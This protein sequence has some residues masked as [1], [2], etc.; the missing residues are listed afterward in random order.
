MDL[1]AQQVF[2]LD[3]LQ[4][5]GFQIVPFPMYANYVGVRKGRC[6]ALL[7]PIPGGAFSIY[8]NPTVLIAGNFTARLTREGRDVFVWKKEQLEA[9]P[10]RLAELES[11]A[12]ALSETI[13]PVE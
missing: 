8:A 7:A 3:R 11:F 4:S 9:T 5:L 2:V 10:E 13:L 6:A 12:A 1:T